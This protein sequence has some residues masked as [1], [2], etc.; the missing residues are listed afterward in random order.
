MKDA[1]GNN[2]DLRSPDGEGISGQPGDRCFDNTASTEMAGT[3]GRCEAESSALADGLKQMT[4]TFWHLTDQND[5]NGSFPVYKGSGD[6]GWNIAFKYKDFVFHYNGHETDR[7]SGNFENPNEWVF[8][9]LTYNGAAL[10]GTDNIIFYKG[11]KDIQPFVVSVQAEPSETIRSTGDK[12]TIGNVF[13][14]N[15][16]PFDG[17]IDNVRVYDKVLTP[18]EI[19][20]VWTDD[21]G[22]VPPPPIPT[23]SPTPTLT[24]TPTPQPSPTPTHAATPTPSP[25][26]SPT[27][28]PPTPTPAITPT[29]TPKPSPE[30]TPPQQRCS[31]V[32]SLDILIN[33]IEINVGETATVLI[34]VK[35]QE[36]EGLVNIPVT[37]KIKKGNR[38]KVVFLND[39]GDKSSERIVFTDEKGVACFFI[40]GIK[41]GKARV[42]FYVNKEPFNE[43]HD[44]KIPSLKVVLKI[45]VRK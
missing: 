5:G 33:N 42:R 6:E 30:P 7:Q 28:P 18:E 31:E 32:S 34:T 13:G 19:L 10:P 15:N 17:K 38:K 16:F 8:V 26:P 45:R 39:S 14:K 4:V 12:L 25:S 23:P 1:N 41:K 3:G 43:E 40:E 36:G 27:K 37:G 20:R 29:P 9:A 35:C 11:T 22:N 2:A 24:L 21:L 44:Y